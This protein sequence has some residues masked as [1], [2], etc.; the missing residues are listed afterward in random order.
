MLKYGEPYYYVDGLPILKGSK[1][2]VKSETAPNVVFI[3]H[4]LYNYYAFYYTPI[5]YPMGTVWEGTDTFGDFGEKGAILKVSY[6]K[7]LPNLAIFKINM[8]KKT[9]KTTWR[10]NAHDYF[11][12]RYNMIIKEIPLKGEMKR[13]LLEHYCVKILCVNKKICLDVE[14]LIF[15]FL[16]YKKHLLRL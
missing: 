9:V 15:M 1:D 8:D 10:V 2:I 4:P 6:Y 13:Q 11:T 3:N 12:E 16:G 5:D 14:N 7:E